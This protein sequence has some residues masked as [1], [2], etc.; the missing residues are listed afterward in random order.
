ME[1]YHERAAIKKGKKRS[2]TS[3]GT[4]LSRYNENKTCG[5]CET[6][7]REKHAGEATRLLSTVA[8]L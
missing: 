2:C 7:K 6:R 3:C 5:A 4:S 8:W 1:K